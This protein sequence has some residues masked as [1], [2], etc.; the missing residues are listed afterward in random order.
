MMDE[1]AR[2]DRAQSRLRTFS[3][4]AN[5]SGGTS[6]QERQHYPRGGLFFALELSPVPD[7]STD[8]NKSL[9]LFTGD[10]FTAVLGVV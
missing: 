8:N 1:R 7:H 2:F 5:A 9:Q 10:R 4:E 3:S 6:G